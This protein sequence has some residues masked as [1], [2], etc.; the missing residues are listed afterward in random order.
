MA[1]RRMP[2]DNAET[3][4]VVDEVIETPA[5]PTMIVGI[6]EGCERLNIRTKP[7]VKSDV[8]C[9]IKKDTKVEIDESKSTRDFYKVCS[10]D[11]NGYCMKKFIAIGK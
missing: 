11:F 8:V 1:K 10:K 5:E 9:V 6:V 3:N 2:V 7:N 4:E